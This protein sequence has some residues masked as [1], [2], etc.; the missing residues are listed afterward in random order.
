MGWELWNEVDLSDD[1]DNNGAA[2]NIF[3]NNRYLLIVKLGSK[4]TLLFLNPHKSASYFRSI[5]PYAH[6][7]TISFSNNRD[8]FY[9][10]S[11]AIMDY[12]QTH[13]YLHTDMGILGPDDV[14]YMKS[15]YPNKPAF[16]GE[17]GTPGNI[18]NYTTVDPTGLNIHNQ[19]WGSTMAKAAA[20]GFT[21]WWDVYVDPANLYFNWQRLSNFLQGE[22]LD[23]YGYT[24][25][26]LAVNT[27]SKAPFS[28]S[29]GSGW[30]KSPNSKFWV[31]S[32]GTITPS[33]SGLSSVIYGSQDNTQYRNPPSFYITTVVPTY[34]Q[35][36]V[37]DKSTAS[38]VTA[39]VY[40]DG[41]AVVNNVGVTIGMSLSSIFFLGLTLSFRS[42]F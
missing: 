13:D 36:S 21:W 27:S 38:G 41:V 35:F 25:L 16:I 40:V 18:D 5:D 9:D 8:P 15:L 34:F 33:P 1:F 2:A 29:P 26:P 23:A 11:N 4:L 30:G 28:I 19:C 3:F 31:A 20:G 10:A 39:S 7:V 24:S 17:F 14:G 37:A 6:L 22:D 42:S 32:N 12:I